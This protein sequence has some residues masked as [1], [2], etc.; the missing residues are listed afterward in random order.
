MM[1]KED[2]II[3]ELKAGK[4]V[5]LA[6]SRISLFWWAIVIL[7]LIFTVIA[8]KLLQFYIEQDNFDFIYIPLVLL[9]LAI[10]LPFLVFKVYALGITASEFVLTGRFG[11]TVFDHNDLVEAK[12]FSVAL[13]DPLRVAFYTRLTFSNENRK[14]SYFVL[15]TSK[16]SDS[17]IEYP[18]L[19]IKRIKNSSKP[20]R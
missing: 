13:W 14:R 5:I 9:F 15:N 7:S 12:S 20:S 4:Q 3:N 18:D 17:F 11:K 10:L 16:L 19:L 1:R 8:I 2:Q 6:S